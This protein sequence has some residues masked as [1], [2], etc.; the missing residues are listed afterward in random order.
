M[1]WE[2]LVLETPAQQTNVCEDGQT[3]D[4][5][6]LLIKC[7]QGFDHGGDQV[8]TRTDR[9][10]K[11]DVGLGFGLELVEHGFKVVV[12][13]TKTAPRDFYGWNV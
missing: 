2:G 8:C 13:A 10:G 9:L 1:K 7:L 11:D 3:G 12:V 6:A 5:D 4:L